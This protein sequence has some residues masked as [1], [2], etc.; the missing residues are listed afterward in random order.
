MGTAHHLVDHWQ[1]FFSLFQ[2]STPSDA[3]FDRLIARYSEP[4][5][6]YHT[7]QHLEECFREFER[8]RGLAESPG[9][10]GPAL[11]FHDAIYDT[12]AHDNDEKSAA[13]ARRVLADA[14]AEERLQTHI[15]DLI[16][17]T[18]H[19]AMPGTPDQQL[20]VDIDLSILGAPQARFDEYE[21]Q[22]RREYAWVDE[23]I[24]RSVRSSILKEFLARPSIYSTTSFRDRLENSARENLKRSIAALAA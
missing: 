17:V 14:G 12:H 18:R 7:V 10:V 11:F 22:V 4:H 3:E 5:R 16:L 20:L 23:P 19:A 24:F 13:L 2:L 8:A 9:E 1:S 21:R 6:A 15:G